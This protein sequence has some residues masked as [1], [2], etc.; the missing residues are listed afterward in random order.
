ML[1]IDP[2]TSS[3]VVGKMRIAGNGRQAF[4]QGAVE[5]RLIAIIEPVDDDEA[6]FERLNG[7]DAHA[8][9]FGSTFHADLS[10]TNLLPAMLDQLATIV[11]TTTVGRLA[12]PRGLAGLASAERLLR[13]LV[14]P[15]ES[16]GPP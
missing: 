1:G 7:I 9:L 10:R 6:S 15:G 8:R 11:E 5:L 4:H 12:V 14:G 2:A 16:G 13:T 3:A